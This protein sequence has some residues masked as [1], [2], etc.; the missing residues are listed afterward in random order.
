MK[1]LIF[2]YPEYPLYISTCTLFFYEYI[3]VFYNIASFTSVAMYSRSSV[4]WTSN[5]QLL[6]LYGL[7]ND[8]SIRVF[9]LKFA[10]Y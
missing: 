3:E 1:Y 2:H 9:C 6:G 10:F 5:I 8:C 7:G 4:I